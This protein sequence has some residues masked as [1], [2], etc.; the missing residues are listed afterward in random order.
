MAARSLDLIINTQTG[1]LLSGFN[2]TTQNGSTPSFVF[3]DLT[4]ITCRLVQ[5][6]GSAE[7]P[8]ADIDLTNQEVHVAIGTPGSY[9]TAGTFTLT[10]GANTT[11]ALAFDASAA[12]VAA[13][14]NLLASIIAAGGVSVTSAAGG[15]YR[16]VF[17]SVG[18]RTAITTN[19]TALYPTST[20]FI[21]V[22]QTGSASVQ[23]VEFEDGGFDMM[24]NP[25]QIPKYDWSGGPTEPITTIDKATVRLPTMSSIS[26][27]LQR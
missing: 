15:S 1:Q 4:P 13:A 11:T 2:S 5:P 22:A 18:V 3:G 26:V 9:P 16:I 7:R 20:S 25:I 19:T 12:T 17:T 6:S 14:L 27:T 21:A 8:W 10:Y 24:G 23:E